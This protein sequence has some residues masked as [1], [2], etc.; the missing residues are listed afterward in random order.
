VSSC[1]GQEKSSGDGGLFKP[2]LHANRI[3]LNRTAFE[4]AA[5]SQ[6]PHGIFGVRSFEEQKRKGPFGQQK[7]Y[8]A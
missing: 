8:S 6:L 4:V 2:Y 1:K 3:I 7:I 5:G